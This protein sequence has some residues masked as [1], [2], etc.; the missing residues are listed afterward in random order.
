MK[1]LGAASLTAASAFVVP[2]RDV[3]SEEVRVSVEE[4]GN[5][6]YCLAACSDSSDV[7]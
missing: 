7:D 6:A 5:E 3:I 2:T 1:A 4:W